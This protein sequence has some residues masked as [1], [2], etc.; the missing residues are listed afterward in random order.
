MDEDWE[1]D[2]RSL[3]LRDILLKFGGEVYEKSNN[4]LTRLLFFRVRL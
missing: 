4:S 1:K 2:D 3:F